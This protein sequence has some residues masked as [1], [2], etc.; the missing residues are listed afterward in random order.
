MDG[1][2]RVASRE[3]RAQGPGGGGAAASSG[4]GAGGDA[5]GVS[6]ICAG[7]RY[8]RLS[9]GSKGGGGEGCGAGGREASERLYESGE[10]LWIGD[11]A[12]AAVRNCVFEVGCFSRSWLRFG[13][14][15]LG[16]GEYR[17]AL[18]YAGREVGASG[19]FGPAGT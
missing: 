1:A 4:R 17:G 15:V 6:A 7:A 13:E 19:F 3:K 14:C 16:D 10:R 18:F 5:G 11:D 8:V 12:S 2:D 9:G